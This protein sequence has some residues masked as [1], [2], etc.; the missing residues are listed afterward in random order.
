MTGTAVADPNIPSV[1][2]ELGA[3]FVFSQILGVNDNGLAVGYYGDSTASQ[4]GFLYN[5]NTGMY[6]F[7][8]DPAEGFFN[9][10][11]V[12]Q[13]TGITD[14]DEIAGFYTDANGIAHSFIACPTGTACST[15][16]IPEPASL[17]ALG[18]AVLALGLLYRR[19]RVTSVPPGLTS[20]IPDP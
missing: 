20:I 8:D 11:E 7:L 14:S 16:A 15:T 9:G 10:V 4:H 2:E 5:T 17:P 3:T 13:I 6:S 18:V 12:T 1:A 19:H